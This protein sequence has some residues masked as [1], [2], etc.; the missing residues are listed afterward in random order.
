MERDKRR[1]LAKQILEDEMSNGTL[2]HIEKIHYLKDW[3]I[4]A[5]LVFSDTESN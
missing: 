2:E 1:E 3:I 4:D 5:M